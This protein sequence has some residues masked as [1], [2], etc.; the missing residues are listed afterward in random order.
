MKECLAVAEYRQHLQVI[1]VLPVSFQHLKMLA[2]RAFMEGVTGQ[3]S[4][5]SCNLVSTSSDERKSGSRIRD[6]V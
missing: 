5:D 2:G 3:C 4:K 6:F 1:R